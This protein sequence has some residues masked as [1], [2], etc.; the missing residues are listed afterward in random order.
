MREEKAKRK[1]LKHLKKI[2]KELLKIELLKNTLDNQIVLKKG[3]L[4][5][6]LNY[7]G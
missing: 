2:S 4:K 5:E 6:N 3:N 7:I 1:I